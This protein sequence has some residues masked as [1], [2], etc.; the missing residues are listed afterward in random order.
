MPAAIVLP[1]AAAMPNQTPRTFRRPP[2]ERGAVVA[3]ALG[4]VAVVVDASV[5]LDNG[6]SGV[7]VATPP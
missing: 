5:V 2:L 6:V 7:F 3:L 1:T 4:E